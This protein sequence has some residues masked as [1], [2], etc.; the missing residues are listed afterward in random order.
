MKLDERTL[1]W[2]VFVFT[3]QQGD[4]CGYNRVSKGKIKRKGGQKGSRGPDDV[5]YGKLLP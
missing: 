5:G 2:K 4:Y 1:V 3:K